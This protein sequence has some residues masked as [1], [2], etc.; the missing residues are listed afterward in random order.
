MGVIDRAKN[1]MWDSKPKNYSSRGS[2]LDANVKSKTAVVVGT[3]RAGKTTHIAALGKVAQYKA[4]DSANS[5]SKFRVIID[6]GATNI[7][8]DIAELS[9]GHF[10]E[11]TPIR[12]KSIVNQGFKFEWEDPTFLSSRFNA[13]YQA[14][15]PV[16]DY[17]G[18]QLVGLIKQVQKAKT[19]EQMMAINGGTDQLTTTINNA[20]ALIIVINAERAEGLPIFVPEPW[21]KIA[22]MSKHPDVNIHRIVFPILKYKHDTR[23][24]SPPLEKIFIVITACDRLF[25]IAKLIAARTNRP[26]DPVPADGDPRKSNASLNMFMKAFF[27]Q[28]HSLIASLNVN[29]QYFP[30][31][32]ELEGADKGNIQYWDDEKTQPKIKRGNMFDTPDWEHN[33]NRPKF[34]EYW[35]NLEIDSLKEFAIRV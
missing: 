25:P 29:V 23:Q 1:L 24:Y 28:T 8:D 10:P 21:Q 4:S 34:T 6:E 18:E 7:L 5:E 12:E 17:A 2:L 22:G 11:A 14:V 31:Y 27:P 16:L 20:S 33:H 15:M 13:K 32:F 3:M 9:S 26:F 19:I 35:Y 30:S